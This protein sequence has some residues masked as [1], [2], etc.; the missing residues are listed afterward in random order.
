[1]LSRE[2]I[3]RVADLP[4]KVCPLHTTLIVGAP[5]LIPRSSIS[6]IMRYSF[7]CL[8][9]VVCAAFPACDFW[10]HGGQTDTIPFRNVEEAKYLSADSA[11]VYVFNDVATW[12]DFWSSHIVQTRLAAPLPAPAIDFER[13]TAVALFWSPQSGCHNEAEAV[14]R[15][16]RVGPQAARV[17]IGPLPDFGDCRAIVYPVQMI[18]FRKSQ[19]VT[20]AGVRP[21]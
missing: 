14:K 20:F 17:V 18:T 12:E 5:L 3:E 21:Q 7:L 19:R 8:L 15:V 1:M 16:E 13:R 10:G 4:L 11:G 9:L 6:T 2:A